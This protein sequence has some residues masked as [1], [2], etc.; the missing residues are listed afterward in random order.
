MCYT[1]GSPAVWPSSELIDSGHTR[2]SNVD[3]IGHRWTRRYQ[4]PKS[5]VRHVRFVDRIIV[6]PFQTQSRFFEH[7]I[8]HLTGSG[9]RQKKTVRVA[10]HCCAWSRTLEFRGTDQETVNGL[11]TRRTV[12]TT[13]V[14]GI[15]VYRRG[16]RRRY[17]NCIKN[18]RDCG[19]L[20]RMAKI[21]IRGGD[22]DDDDDLHWRAFVIAQ[23]DNCEPYWTDEKSKAAW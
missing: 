11:P 1:I 23:R 5:A 13:S 22:G 2:S 9:P 14:F 7:H 15:Y 3:T 12:T 21:A 8:W 18:N 10:E 20:K 6:L 17:G 4:R 16:K 19:R